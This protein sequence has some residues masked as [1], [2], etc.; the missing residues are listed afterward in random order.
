KGRLAAG[1]SRQGPKHRENEDSFRIVEPDERTTSHGNLYVVCDGVGGHQKGEVASALAV[2]VIERAYYGG[3]AEGAE[4]NLVTAINEANRLVHESAEADSGEGPSM[5][6]T[7]VA[8]AVLD[9][10]IIVGNVGDSR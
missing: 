1:G 5:A 2:D 10:Q 3:A 6:T 4:A 8:A 7:V 9:E